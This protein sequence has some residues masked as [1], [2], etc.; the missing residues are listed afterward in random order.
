MRADKST[1]VALLQM[2]A[3]QQP[4]CV[5]YTFVS[6]RSREAITYAE[7]DRRARGVGRMLAERHMRGSPVMLLCPPGL[8]YVAGFFGCLY[9]GAI[10]VP[11]YLPERARSEEQLGDPHARLRHYP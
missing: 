7:L 2:R 4:D 9:A 1:I 8:D 10:A 3:E 6:D 11:A 5:A